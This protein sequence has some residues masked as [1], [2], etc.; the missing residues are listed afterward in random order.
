VREQLAQRRSAEQ[1]K[2]LIGMLVVLGLL[3]L[4]FILLIFR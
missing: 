2:L 3:L 1:L 4:P